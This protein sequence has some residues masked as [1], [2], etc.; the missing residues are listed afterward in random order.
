MAKSKCEAIGIDLGTTYSAIAFSKDG[1]AEV[2]ANSDGRKTTPS[3]VAFV[4]KERIVG[5]QAFRQAQ[6]SPASVIFDSKRMIGKLYDEESVKQDMVSWPFNVERGPKGRPVIVCDNGAEKVKLSPEEVGGILLRELKGFAERFLDHEVKNVVITCPASFNDAQRQATMDAAKIAGLN[7]IRLLNEPTAAA[8]AYG[9]KRDKD[10]SVLIFD[11]GG[12]TFDATILSI[13]EGVYEVTATG[14]DP[15]LG[16]KDLDNLVVNHVMNLYNKN[17]TSNRCDINDIDHVESKN[18][19]LKAVEEAKISLS[20]A[21]T[22]SIFIGSFVKTAAGKYLDLNLNLSRTSLEKIAKP[23][24]DRCITMTVNLLKENKVKKSDIEKVVLVGGFT[25][26]PFLREQLMKQFGDIVSQGVNPDEAVALGA[27]L[28]AEVYCD[29][30]KVVKGLP[31][32]LLDVTPL[33]LG[34]EL[35]NGVMSKIIQSNTPVPTTMEDVYTTSYNQQSAVKIVVYQGNRSFVKDNKKLGMFKLEGIPK[36]ER[37]KAEIHVCFSICADGVLSIKASE[38]SSGTVNKLTIAKDKIGGLT[39]QELAK[40][41]SDGEKFAE[42]DRRKKEMLLQ[43]ETLERLIMDSED[44]FP[45]EERLTKKLKE[46]SVWLEEDDGKEVEE[47]RQK[48]EE[49]QKIILETENAPST[50]VVVD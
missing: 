49:L 45:A 36:M 31:T 41:I 21:P 35:E 43:K 46:V 38:S 40:M 27:A 13:K 3:V 25:K 23:M 50:S 10:G 47:F 34:I 5:E 48:I 2:I 6:C 16:G 33:A 12:G 42:D 44:R 37:G 20:S 32:L 39:E 11:L 7:C 30:T 22:T 28:M 9:V 4:G 26:M 29:E 15:H 18:K 1:R 8:V 19:L 24:V 14:G 17:K